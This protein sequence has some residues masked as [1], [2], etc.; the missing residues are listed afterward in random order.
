[1]PLPSDKLYTNNLNVEGWTF[2]RIDIKFPQQWSSLAV[3]LHPHLK[4]KIINKE[5]NSHKLLLDYISPSVPFSHLI[6]QIHFWIPF[7]YSTN[8]AP[9]IFFAHNKF[10]F[11]KRVFFAVKYASLYPKINSFE[12]DGFMNA[13]N[14]IEWC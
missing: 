7:N 3:T 2:S 12:T 9:V 13:M 5:K 4:K 1:M 14:G 11:Q 10:F 6:T 8:E